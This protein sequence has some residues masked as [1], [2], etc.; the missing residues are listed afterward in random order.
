MIDSIVSR[1]V[2]ELPQND[3]AIVSMAHGVLSIAVTVALRH[4][5]L[6]AQLSVATIP[7]FA[8]ASLAVMRNGAASDLMAEP[9]VYTRYLADLP[10]ANSA[11]A[12]VA[13]LDVALRREVPEDAVNYLRPMCTR[14]STPRWF[15]RTNPAH[16]AAV[17]AHTSHA[18]DTMAADAEGDA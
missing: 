9:E 8:A 4:P 11:T 3:T 14:R 10:P 6:R 15:D 2:A 7:L 12:H 16:V 18:A 17:A 5:E 13:A 1:A